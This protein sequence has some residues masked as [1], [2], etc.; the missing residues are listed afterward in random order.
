MAS[1]FVGLQLRGV[2]C[3]QGLGGCFWTVCV[4]ALVGDLKLGF[5]WFSCFL[6]WVLPA[7]TQLGAFCFF[8]CPAPLVFRWGIRPFFGRVCCFGAFLE[9][10]HPPLIE[11]R[12]CVCVRSVKFTLTPT[13]SCRGSGP[14]MSLL[15][16]KL[17]MSWGDI[18]TDHPDVPAVANVC[19]L[20]RC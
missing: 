6:F 14:L 10:I 4:F 17:L 3:L 19:A 7:G 15:P 1:V 2:L 18:W 11:G 20:F 9:H 16:T 5:P 13:F 12:V 8:W